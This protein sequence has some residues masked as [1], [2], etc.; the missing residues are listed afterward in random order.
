[1]HMKQESTKLVVL[2]NK[3]LRHDSATFTVLFC[4]YS[5]SMSII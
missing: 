3:N 1:M 4:L 5:P 2:V